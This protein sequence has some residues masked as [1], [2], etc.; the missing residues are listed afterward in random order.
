MK[1]LKG[2]AETCY[3]IAFTPT[4]RLV[5]VSLDYTVRLWDAEACTEIW[6]TRYDPGAVPGSVAVSPDGTLVAVGPHWGGPLMVLRTATGE[7]A[8]REGDANGG[9]T[10]FS[11]DGRWVALASGTGL[12]LWRTDTF[13]P[14]T[15]PLPWLPWGMGRFAVAFSPDGKCM[16]TTGGI[17]GAL[18]IY[19]L[20][21]KEVRHFVVGF[22][23][24][25][26]LLRYSPDGRLLVG[27]SRKTLKVVDV[28]SGSVVHRDD[29]PN[30]HYQSAAFSPDGRLL[31]AAAN[32]SVV[33]FWDTATWTV[34]ADFAWRIGQVL[35]VTFAPDGMRAAASG[36]SGK[37]VVWDVDD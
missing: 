25:P 21:A 29:L 28:Q 22:S 27:I 3:A 15:L 30:R 8:A 37:V 13:A 12:G 35:D 16:A 5:S 1:I 36:R 18:P 33:R 10:A 31:A 2:H 17:G 11:A 32:D 23:L 20:E 26:T 19:D 7:V 34:K 9:M 6:R 4:A 24:A 14:V